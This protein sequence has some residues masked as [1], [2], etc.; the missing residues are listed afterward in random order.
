MAIPT[1]ARTNLSGEYCSGTNNGNITPAIN[2]TVTNGTPRT[3]S[4]KMTDSDRTASIRDRRPSARRIPS[5]SENT[6]P[7]DATTIVTSTPPQ[8]TVSTGC[9]PIADQPVSSTN[10][11]TGKITKK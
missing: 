11:E 8:S 7:T 4:M 9:K 1:S 10:D 3:N 5:G 6:I 2:S